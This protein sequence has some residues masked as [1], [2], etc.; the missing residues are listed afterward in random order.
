MSDGGRPGTTPEIGPGSWLDS[1][2]HA[3]WL[4]EQSRSLLR[5]YQHVAI[6]PAGGF[7]DLEADRSP[8]A[9][10]ARSLVATTR[11]IHCYSVAHS[12][13]LPGAQRMVEHGIRHMDQLWDESNGGWLWARSADG[14]MDARKL[15]YGHA[16]AILAG[17][18]ATDAGIAGGVELLQRAIDLH[19]AYYWDDLAGAARDEYARDWSEVKPYR[20]QNGNMH[21]VEAY[22]AAAAVTGDSRFLD[23]SRRIAEL[24]INTHAR[25]ME[26]RVPEHYSAQWQADRDFGRDGVFDVWKPFGATVGHGFEWSRL[27]LQLWQAEGRRTAWLPEAARALYD[28]AWTDGWDS[29]RGGLIFTT[30]WSGQPVNSDRYHWVIA[31]AIA[32]SAAM[33][34]AFPGVTDS[35]QR[36]RTLWGFADQHMI[37]H[38]RGG[39][40]HQLDP[41]N[42]VTTDPWFG[43][44]DLYHAFTACVL[45]LIGAL[46][47]LPT[48][49]ARE[50][51]HAGHL[52]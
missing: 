47:P 21:L 31:E 13:G 51:A 45:P 22:L 26:W 44:P 19:D 1:R 5:F 48:T 38:A 17:S 30:D 37:D 32:A 49:A 25:A 2:A 40:Y 33:S 46:S 14:A 8:A 52:S 18:S 36:Y 23:R 15:N 4:L 42:A 27:L 12:A 9:P 41:R 34:T 16:F 6:D 50:W 10:T 7:F 35:E 3:A 20:G 24:I 28:R 43:K 11:M 39:W 29:E